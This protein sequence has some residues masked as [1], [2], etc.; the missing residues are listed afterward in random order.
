MGLELFKE[1]LERAGKH[2]SDALGIYDVLWD[3]FPEYR[4][5]IKTRSIIIVR[6][7]EKG[8]EDKEGWSDTPHLSEPWDRHGPK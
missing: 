3:L 1:R 5:E 7:F 6:T 2:L 4:E 8:M